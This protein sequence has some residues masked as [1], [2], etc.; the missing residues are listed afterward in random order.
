MASRF[1]AIQAPDFSR[2]IDNGGAMRPERAAFIGPLSRE[3]A[4]IGAGKPKPGRAGKQL[5]KAKL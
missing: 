3:A 1:E 4:K 2:R 5:A